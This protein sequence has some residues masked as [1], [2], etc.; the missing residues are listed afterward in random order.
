[1]KRLGITAEKAENTSM[2]LANV[3]YTSYMLREAY[4]GGPAEILAAVLP[5]A[6]SYQEI[7]EAMVQNHPDCINHPFYGEWVQG[8]ASPEY[9]ACNQE[10]LAMT[11]RVTEGLSEA[12]V[13]HLAEIAVR[14][15]RYEGEFWEMSWKMKD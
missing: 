13:D 10:M 11:D 7:A 3:S 6:V 8:Y 2:A 12:S 4:E 9:R 1:M 15:C 5:C 14:C